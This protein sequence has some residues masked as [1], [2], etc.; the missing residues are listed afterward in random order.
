M[1]SFHYLQDSPILSVSDHPSLG[2]NI[3][4]PS[5]IR[6][7]KWLS[8]SPARY[9]LYFAH[10]EGDSIRL[11]VSDYMD[12][13]WRIH[14]PDPLQLACSHFT[15]LSPEYSNL[16]GEVRIA[17]ENGTD[18]NYPHIASPDIWVDHE[19]Q[20]IRMYYHGRQENGLQTTRV[21]VSRDGVNFDAREEILGNPYCRVF[22]HDGY[23]YA[24]SMPAQLYR[25]I[26]GLSGFES[27]PR[28]TEEPIRHHALLQHQNQWYLFW[29]RVGDSPER[30]LVSEMDVSG[31]WQD[32][33]IN[34]GQEVH[35][36]KKPWEGSEVIAEAS[37]YGSSMQAV[38]QL[39][40]PAIYVENDCIYLL[41]AIAGEQGIA[42]GELK[43]EPT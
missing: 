10:H 36:A 17:I 37:R 18:G 12:G 20:Q 28:L 1:F 42:I 15:T 24:I 33:S 8:N 22:Q 9:L 7:P 25:S 4:G 31:D 6:S 43:L 26:D 30:I 21:A 32:W 35:R 34:E 29:T 40:D 41:Y 39:R 23:F 38:N 11:A 13:P 27:G 3:N 2:G 19:K 16:V 14:K 5:L